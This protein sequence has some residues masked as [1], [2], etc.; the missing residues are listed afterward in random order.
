VSDDER[1]LH[2]EGAREPQLRAL[3]TRV[4]A[5]KREALSRLPV[6]VVR[7]AADRHGRPREALVVCD[8]SG[9]LRAYRNLCQHLP[10]PLDSG[11]RSFMY[12][13]DLQCLTHGARYRTSD[14]LCVYGPCK[15]AKLE[16]FVVEE[17]GDEIFVVDPDQR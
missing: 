1:V 11:S 7:L 5:G 4:H 2:I 8:E 3:G 17:I 14:G 10:I 13:G 6:L 12:Q 9:A 16:A 15:G